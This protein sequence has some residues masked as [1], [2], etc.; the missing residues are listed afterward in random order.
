M[1][2]WEVWSLRARSFW[3]RPVFYKEPQH[4]GV[5]LA[6]VA[7]F[8]QGVVERLGQR[9][10]VILPIAQL[11]HPM[12]EG[13]LHPS[14]CGCSCFVTFGGSV[15]GLPGHGESLSGP[16]GL[17]RTRAEALLASGE[18]NC[19]PCVMHRVILQTAALCGAATHLPGEPEPEARDAL[20]APRIGAIPGA[21]VVMQ[22]MRIRDCPWIGVAA[23]VGGLF[24]ANLQALSA[25]TVSPAARITLQPQPGAMQVTA[26]VPCLGKPAFALGIPETIG[27]REAMLVNFPQ[28]RIKAG[29]ESVFVRGFG[30]TSS[31]R[32]AG[33]WIV[34]LSEPAGAY[35]A[36]TATEAAF[37]FDNLELRWR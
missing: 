12:G 36:T 11:G 9:L 3:E 34:T 19:N 4:A 14:P 8:K 20:Q 29:E 30:A 2:F 17:S 24:L 28:E 31:D 26:R 6:D 23:V 16:F 37:L 21:C 10:A 22:T 15:R 5:Q 7:Q 25:E 13:G 18:Q 1:F 27:C 32:T 35:M 33:S